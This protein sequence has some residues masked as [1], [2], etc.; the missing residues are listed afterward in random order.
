MPRPKEPE[1]SPEPGVLTVYSDIGCPWAGL[2]LHGLRR[3]RHRLGLK[4]VRIDLRAY[5]LELLRGTPTPKRR[6]DA[7]V[8]VI[9][10]LDETLAWQQWQ[11]RADEWPV[12]T[13]LPMEAVQAAKRPDV[14]GLAASDELD[15]ALRYAMFGQS[16]CISLLPEILAV[17]AECERVN[18]E[19][20]KKALALGAGRAEVMTQW[21]NAKDRAVHGSPHVFLPDG[22]EW[23]NPG[24][25]VRWTGP[26]P[27]TGFPVILSYDPTVYDEIVTT[28]TR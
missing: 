27:E 9:G 15:A 1:F 3:A 7:E 22:S 4:R 19:A 11:G 5:P 8:P 16:R 23:H 17:A 18:A 14:G 26:E 25:E 21:R 10:G 2:A 28:A 20:L 6:L 24:V 13:L 12:S